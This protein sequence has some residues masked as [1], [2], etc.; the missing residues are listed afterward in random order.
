M[1]ATHILLIQSTLRQHLQRIPLRSP[2]TPCTL[3]S[4]TAILF[5][6]FTL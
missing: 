2:I 1:L 3:N 4:F 5:R 6:N